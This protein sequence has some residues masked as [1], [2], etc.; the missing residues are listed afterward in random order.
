MKHP[1]KWRETIDPTTLPLR[2]FKLQ[3]ILG[4]PHAGNDVF[5]VCGA[6]QG[7]TVE[8]YIKVA[9]HQEANL[10]RETLLLQTLNMPGLP[11]LLEWDEQFRYLVT[12]ACPGQRLS[13][14]LGDNEEGQSLQYMAAYGACLARWHRQQGDFPEAPHRRFMDVPDAQRCQR[15]GLDAVHEWLISHKPEA[16][17]RC[18]CHGDFHYANLLWQDGEVSGILDLELAGMGDREFD[19]AWAMIRRP[20]Q[21]FM[22]TQE[23][24]DR[25][26]EGYRRVGRYDAKRLRWYMVCAYAWFCGIGAEDEQYVTWVRQWLKEHT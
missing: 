14:I 5:Q 22:R 21:K 8:A 13:V 25:F 18:F 10:Q 2:W 4:Y 3:E 26:L 9:R 16:G 17:E 11:R 7:R 20:G 15:L 6:Y 1:E 12:E 23:E 24:H 19:M